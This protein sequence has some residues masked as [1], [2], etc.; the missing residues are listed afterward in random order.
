MRDS[1]RLAGQCLMIGFEGL[2]PSAEVRTLLREQS[3]GGIILFSRNVADPEQVAGLVQEL[4]AVARGAG[5][6]LP[7]LVGIDQEGGRVARLR[8]PWTEWPPLRALGQAGS[9]DLARGFG[10][11]LAEQ[12][13]PLGIRLDFAPVMD[14]ATNAANPVIGDRSFGDDPSLVAKLGAAFIRGLQQGGVA[15]SAKHFPGHGDTDVDSHLDLP[16][17]D[18][19]RAR[20]ED[21]ELRPFRA[22][23]AAQV[24]T[25]MTAHVLAR[26]IDDR[27]PAT[28]SPRL[29]RDVLRGELGFA[30][31]VVS[32]DLEMQAIAKRWRSG[33]AA[34]LALEAGCDLLLVCKSADAQ[35]EAHE[36][37]VKAVEQGV[38]SRTAL[39]DVATRVRRLKERFVAQQDMRPDLKAA[40][41][42][43]A[44]T[45]HLALAEE[46]AQRGGMRA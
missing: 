38:L 22:A 17:V 19:T 34:A 45:A 3:V 7:L 14:V 30:G 5:Q 26:E 39:E 41:A 37:I 6:E 27:L 13:A 40:R 46:I 1:V 10:A 25:I 21:V 8:N 9:E 2:Q 23:I 16:A 24:A 4:Q 32:D 15:A 29:V 28:L 36:A 20:L 11:A 44:S 42:S 31:V 12:L 43:A 18:H 33:P 35:A